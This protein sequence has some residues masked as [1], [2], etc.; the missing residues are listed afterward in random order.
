VAHADERQCPLCGASVTR[1]RVEEDRDLYRFEDHDGC[2]P[3][4]VT[5]QRLATLRMD[6]AA[7]ERRGGVGA[8]VIPA[9]DD[10]FPLVFPPLWR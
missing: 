3:F 10:D 6:N 2:G 8:R 4:F 5:K 7:D 9:P 1:K